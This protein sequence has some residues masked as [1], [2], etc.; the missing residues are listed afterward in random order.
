MFRKIKKIDRLFAY[1]AN[2]KKERI[3]MNRIKN[4]LEKLQHKPKQFRII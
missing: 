1:V 3:E 2:R 4:M